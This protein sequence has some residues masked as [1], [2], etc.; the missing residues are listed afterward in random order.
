MIATVLGLGLASWCLGAGIGTERAE[1]ARPPLA[2]AVH[3]DQ[4]K[5]VTLVIEDERG[6]RVRNLISEAPLPAGDNIVGWD[7]LDDLGRDPGAASHGVYHVP[8]K[9]VPAGVYRVRGL[10]H[11]PLD[12]KYEFTPYFPGNPPWIT[13]DRSSGWLA[14][15][16]PASAVCFIP[17]GEVPVRKGQSG[18]SPAQ[19][20]VGSHVSEGGS[21]VAWVGLDGKKLHGQ[22]WIGGVWTGAD[23]IA[24]DLGPQPRSAVYAYTGSYW[25]GDKFNGFKSELRLYELQ[26]TI[27]IEKAPKD[28]RF[29]TGEDYAVLPSTYRLEPRQGSQAK[30]RFGGMAVYNGILV[31]SIPANDQLVFI[32]TE[33]RRVIGAATLAEVGGITYDAKGRLFAI[34]GKEVVRFDSLPALHGAEEATTAPATSNTPAIELRAPVKVITGGLEEPQQVYVHTNGDLYVSDWGNSHNVKVFSA[35]GKFLRAIGEAGKPHV[36]VYNPNQMQ[37]PYGLTIDGE[38]HL[39]VAEKES[40]PKRLSIWSLAG[41]LERAYYG[42]PP[43]GSGGCIDSADPS[44]F[45]FASGGGMEIHLDWATGENHPVNVYSRSDDDSLQP[46]RGESY[47]APQLPIHVGDRIYLTDSYNVSPIQGISTS[48]LWILKNGRAVPAAL[49]GQANDLTVFN[50]TRSF[51]VRW[52]GQVL[53]STTDEYTFYTTV[54]HGARLYVDGKLVIQKWQNWGGEGSGKI[55]LE[56]GKRYDICMEMYHNNAAA[57][58][59]LGW[60]N[61]TIKRQVIPTAQLFPTSD[62]AVTAGAGLT[63]T[64]FVDHNLKEVRETRIDPKVEFNWGL[65]GLKFSAEN[66][67]KAR[68]PKGTDLG[69]DHVIFVWSDL[70]D[71]GIVQPEEISTFSGSTGTVCFQ[72]DL[73]ALTASGMQFKPAGFTPAGAPIYDAAHMQ[74]LIKS[75]E[76]QSSPSDG[77]GQALLDDAGNLLLTTAPKPFSASSLGGATEGTARWSYPSLWP[78]LHAS[79][80]GALPDAPGMLV[81]TTRLLGIPFKPP[82]ADVGSLFA[83]N[84]N[85]GVIYLM[86]TDGLFVSTLFRDCRVASWNAPQ[87]IRGMSVKDLS[88]NEETFFPTITQ[89]KDGQ[90]YLQ[91]NGRILHVVGLDTLRKL[92]VTELTITP[93]LLA[94]AQRYSLTVEAARQRALKDAAPTQADIPITGTA[95][96]VDGKFDDWKDAKWLTIDNRTIQVGDWGKRKL[97]T[98]ASLRVADGKLFIALKTDTADLLKNSGDSLQ[99]LFKTGGGI[100]LFLGTDPIA[101]PARKEP[102]VG[103]ERL[104]IAQANDKTIAVM[105]RPKVP[106]TKSDPVTF[107]S[108]VRSLK[109]DRVEAVSDQV[110]LASD[111]DMDEKG[112]VKEARY[113]IAIPLETLHLTPKANMTIR[114]DIGVI[115]GNGFQAMQRVYWSNKATGLMSDIPSQAE[116]TPELWGTW[117]FRE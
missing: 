44:R 21:G 17:A 94:E 22:E 9:L 7:G 8:G 43:Y 50:P 90:V 103:D 60:A 34:V 13:A 79:H 33:A 31:A 40:L 63:A 74:Q 42:P 85:K 36:G 78:G 41:K 54:T 59:S 14:N 28:G 111:V 98:A 15:H 92:P 108:P 83:I 55:K 1:D 37:H 62:A 53:A 72:T 91:G 115:R 45:F 117:T 32:D 58:A 89:T 100:D 109:M 27:N 49:I 51:S 82:G 99:N 73:S 97:M 86:T 80:I 101:D 47:T 56:A 112:T 61:S 105:Y 114:G 10:V 46:F 102:A 2:I 84:G 24:R 4:P 77:G 96:V 57:K 75:A 25:E 38:G 29:G 68:L 93:A 65:T 39:W 116:L 16:T 87:A 12:I 110:R 23:F 20:V 52:T 95:P 70:N 6:V 5:L 26:K 81:G 69:K 67:F 71:D 76:T 18:P 30:V 113:E 107:E 66:P 64:Y 48:G 19:V 88:L 11:D 35:E 106:G 104:L 3:L